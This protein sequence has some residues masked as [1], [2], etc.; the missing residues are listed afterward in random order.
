L[1]PVPQFLD[2]SAALRPN[3]H[4]FHQ[5][6]ISRVANSD[7]QLF[8]TETERK[9]QHNNELR[10]MADEAST[11]TEYDKKWKRQYEKLVEFKRTNGHCAVPPNYEQDKPLGKWVNK[12]QELQKKNK[13]R[14]DRRDLLD[15]VG[16]A[17]SVEI[18]VNRH[19]KQ[20][21]LQYEKLVEFKRK[22][23]H[24]IVPY[25]YLQDNSLGNWVAKQ[26]EFEKK[27]IMRQDRKD[28]LNEVEFVW[29]ARRSRTSNDVRC[30]VIE[31]FRTWVR[32]SFSFS[33]FLSNVCVGFGVGSI[34]QQCGSPKRST[35]GNG[36]T[37]TKSR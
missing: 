36:R 34:H 24:C 21:R 35:R 19:I 12:Q 20:W 30:L 1:F 23:G 3:F 37:R 7:P 6:N 4:H 10:A 15:E 27:N 9:R 22:N 31:S 2:K 33:F 25:S 26:R 14:Q 8:K 11:R 18:A 16:F 29:S 5:L 32:S 13:M 17:W 28:L